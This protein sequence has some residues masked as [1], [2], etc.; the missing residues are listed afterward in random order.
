MDQAATKPLHYR[1]QQMRGDAANLQA[2]I[3]RGVSFVPAL[4]FGLLICF[5]LMI[6]SRVFDMYFISYHIPGICER[7]MAAVVIV[8]GSFWRPFHTGIG[9]TLLFLTAWMVIG[10]PFSAW[11]SDSLSILTSAWWP[12]LI[13][14]MAVGGMIKEFK[15]YCVIAWILA[16]SILV[17]SI[18][19]LRYGTIDNGRL[20]M[21]NESR[22]ANPNDM[23]Q[24][25]LIG[26]P[27]WLAI[28]KRSASLAGKLAAL[29]VLV[30]MVYVIAQ[31]G[32][33][34]ALLS[35]AALFVA[36]LLRAS[37]KGK[38]KLLLAGGLCFGAA[39]GF[40]PG[41]LQDRY[42]TLFS[43]DKPEMETAGED[44][45]LDSAFSSTASRQHLLDQS[46]IL[47]ATHPIFGVG[48][49]QFMVAENALAISQGARRGSWLGTHNTYT[50]VA[51]ETGLPGALLFIAVFFLSMKTTHS[52]YQ[53]TKGEAELKAVAIQAEALF[54]S[55][56][57]L[58]TTDIFIHVAYTML[59][60]VL[61]G[62][63]ISLEYTSRP[64]IAE[65]QRRKAEL[66]LPLPAI[67]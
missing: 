26:I 5:L 18:F 22:F 34:G 55:L 21:S 38:A 58:A 60:P 42:K 61:A 57:C 31:T 23:A 24:A 36:M 52:L 7:I 28:S 15:Q 9:K 59:L 35:F 41:S 13:V 37:A 46:L 62:L 14:F 44:L 54:F 8:S 6:F 2:D 63:A 3:S 43:E 19:C 45:M 33:R 16:V 27:F 40:L 1:T 32:S 47:T 12:C 17:L 49:G 30:V 51:S 53:A 67:R 66:P 64:L 48:I 50:Q 4:G 11:K 39:L 20:W 56:I 10:V 25:M 65:I 29:G